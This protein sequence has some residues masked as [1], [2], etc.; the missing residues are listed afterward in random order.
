M[1]KRHSLLITSVMIITL[2]FASVGISSASTVNPY[3]EASQGMIATANPLATHVGLEMLLKGGNA[4]DA[5]VAAAF[6][7]GVVEPNASGMGGGGFMVFY[8]A[9]TDEVIALDYREIASLNATDDMYHDP[10][11]EDAQR[12]GP[13][14]AGVPGQVAGLL[15]ALENYGTL[16]REE[17]LAPS[18]RYADEGLIVSP[19]LAGMIA[20]RVGL[21]TRFPC[22]GEVYLKDGEP[23]EVGD[24]LYQKDK[25]NTLRLIAEKGVDGFY[26]GSVAEAFDTYMRENGGIITKEDLAHYL[27]VRPRVL[28]AAYGTYKGYQIYSM[29]PPSSGGTHI[30]Q[31]LNILENF[32]MRGYG[33]NSPESIHLMSEAMKRAFADRSAYMAD[34]AFVELPIEGLTSKEYA[35]DLAATIDMD[36]PSFYLDE[37]DPFKYQSFAPVDAYTLAQMI[38][39]DAQSTTHLSVADA[40]GNIVAMTN[41]INFFFGA[42]AVVSG[43]GVKLNNQPA[44]FDS[45]PGRVNSPEPGKTPLSSMSPTI[46]MTPDG[47]PFLSVGTPGATRIFPSVMQILLNIIDYDMNIQEAIEA[48]RIFAPTA[49]IS[50]EGRIPYNVI[51]ALEEMGHALNVRGDWDLFF[52]GA[53]GV[54]VDEKTGK[55][56]GG[57]DPRREGSVMGY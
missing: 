23:F 24:I 50:L 15:Y 6:A 34:P 47:K 57:A 11:P 33:H 25:A 48:P 20:G 53:Q 12:Y 42:H 2:I 18:I 40:Q 13:L 17:I 37:G 8:D 44:N 7:L 43:T 16:S 54:F 27:E 41:T 51:S 35:R 49:D 46:V 28:E 56:I 4:V 26:R 55:L 39:E 19:L 32:D 52:G 5:A 14:A 29:S 22:A 45:E 31:M 38:P 10:D 21:F 1:L 9:E 3:V 36:I 30:V